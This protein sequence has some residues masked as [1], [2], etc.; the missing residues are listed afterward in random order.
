[1]TRHVPHVIRAPRHIS[2]SRI[3]HACDHWERYA[4][5]TRNE[6]EL[7][8][9][10]A[11]G[12]QLITQVCLQCHMQARSSTSRSPATTSV[13]A[14]CSIPC[15]TI[16]GEKKWRAFYDEGFIGRMLSRASKSRKPHP[17][18]RRARRRKPHPARYASHQTSVLGSASSMSRNVF[19]G[20]RI[21][22]TPIQSRKRG[23]TTRSITVANSGKPFSFQ[24]EW[25]DRIPESSALFLSYALCCVRT[26][27]FAKDLACNCYPE[28]L[29]RCAIS[30][31]SEQ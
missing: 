30:E 29:A 31:R 13:T 20:G 16:P 6:Q 9:A 25:I 5:W 22:L 27:F 23:R 1:M 11:Q 10:R 8:S 3:K 28:V 2:F 21:R 12:E 17:T 15:K 7:V 24:N 26:R 18:Q 19:L 4:F 14:T